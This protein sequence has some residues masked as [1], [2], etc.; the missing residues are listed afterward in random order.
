[1]MIY[2]YLVTLEKHQT[3]HIM[4]YRL[5]RVTNHTLYGNILVFSKLFAFPNMARMHDDILEFA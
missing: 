2:I 4:L 5:S 3:F 1:M